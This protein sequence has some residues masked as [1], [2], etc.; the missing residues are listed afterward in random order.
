MFDRPDVIRQYQWDLSPDDLEKSSLDPVRRLAAQ[1][2]GQFLKAAFHSMPKLRTVY[3]EMLDDDDASSHLNSE[4][5]GVSWHIVEAIAST[6]QLRRFFVCGS[7]CHPDDELPN[8]ITLPPTIALE[9][10]SY[11]VSRFRHPRRTTEMERQGV[12]LL[13]ERMHASLVSLTLSSG[14][15]PLH[16]LDAWDWPQLTSLSLYGERSVRENSPSLVAPLRKMPRLRE[17]SL[18]L[19]EPTGRDLAPVW[20]PSLEP[21]CTWPELERLQ[22]THPHPEDRLYA[23]L[24]ASLQRLSLRCWPRYY[25]HHCDLNEDMVEAGV[26]WTSPL[27]LSSEMLRLLRKSDTPNLTHLELEFRADPAAYGDIF[28]HIGSSYSHLT[29][30]QIHCYRSEDGADLS[31]VRLRQRPACDALCTG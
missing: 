27:L 30:V 1:K 15:A 23:H 26:R 17:L 11:T 2:L 16:H 28:A 3:I 25:K 20:P 9:A 13:L 7:M 12:L 19:A 22:V 31:V 24:P 10:F 5:R 8:D 21:S 4:G 18:L 14:S 29:V 6:P